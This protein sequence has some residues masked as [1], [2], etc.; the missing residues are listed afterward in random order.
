MGYAFN[1]ELSAAGATATAINVSGQT[2]LQTDAQ[3]Q[4][5]YDE[6]GFNTGQF[7]LLSG[8][9]S[10]QVLNFCSS[11]KTILWVRQDP[12]GAPPATTLYVWTDIGQVNV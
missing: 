11:G 1:V 10:P 2:I 5:A 8:A 12:E 6:N 4:I 9:N 7:T 3:L